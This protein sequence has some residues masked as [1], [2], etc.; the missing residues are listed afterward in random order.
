[1][2]SSRAPGATEPPAETPVAAAPQLC[3]ERP[4]APGLGPVVERKG[5][6]LAPPP[7]LKLPLE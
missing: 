2:A 3:S 4:L 1:M 7:P 5:L 6:P